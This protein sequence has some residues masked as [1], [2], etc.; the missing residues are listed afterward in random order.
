M[1]ISWNLVRIKADKVWGKC[2]GGNVRIAVLDTGVDRN[3]PA[4]TQNVSMSLDVIRGAR[5]GEDECGHGTYVAGIIAAANKGEEKVGVAPEASLCCLKVLDDDAHGDPATL[6]RG[7][8]WCI[9]NG[10]QIINMSLGLRSDN[11]SVREIIQLAANSGIL[12]IAAA[13]N[14]GLGSG[15]VRFPAAYDSVVA[16]TGTDTSDQISPQ[17]SWGPEVDLCAPGEGINSTDRYSRLPQWLREILPEGT[18]RVWP[19]G[20]AWSSFAAAHVSGVAALILSANASITPAGVG[21]ILRDTAE[22]L[23]LP[24]ISQGA[25]LVSAE[26]AIEKAVTYPTKAA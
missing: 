7:I 19:G 4:L 26:G 12:L 23:G 11:L 18:F 10:M 14:D 9:T 15:R 24:S 22:D 1:P 17:S 8:E 16:V 21:E 5:E 2:R 3:H 13:G 6:V 20:G 25:G